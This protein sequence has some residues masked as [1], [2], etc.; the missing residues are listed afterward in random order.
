MPLEKWQDYDA[1]FQLWTKAGGVYS[2][3]TVRVRGAD[4]GGSTP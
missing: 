2:D 3:L 1:E 4:A